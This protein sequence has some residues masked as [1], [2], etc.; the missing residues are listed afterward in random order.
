[1]GGSR[2]DFRV[3]LGHDCCELFEVDHSVSVSVRELNHL[4]HFGAR[5][6][7]SH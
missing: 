6:V 4:V 7:L 3:D 1:M 5:E 2:S